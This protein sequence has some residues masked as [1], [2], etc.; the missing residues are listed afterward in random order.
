MD[1]EMQGGCLCGALRYSVSAMPFDSDHC[2]C[3]MCQKSTGAVVGSWMDFLVDQVTWLCGKPR[4]YASSDTTRRGFCS[5][6]GTSISFR[7]TGHPTYYTLS[8][9]SLDDPNLVPVKYHIHTDSQLK[10]LIIEDD[11]PRYNGSR[12]S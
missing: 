2:H 6:C 10:W 3:R 4:E 9:A 12:L 11:L 7:D 8:I 1:T 5:T